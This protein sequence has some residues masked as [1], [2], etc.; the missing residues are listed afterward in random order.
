MTYR[1]KT[2]GLRAGLAA[3]ALALCASSAQAALSERDLFSPFDHAI[4]YDSLTTYEWLDLTK[5]LGQSYNAVLLTPYVTE[6]GFRFATPQE[7][8]Q[9]WSDTG[10]SQGT[11]FENRPGVSLLINLL[12][13][14]AQCVPGATAAAQ[15]W[16]DMGDP[17]MTAYSFVQ[18][19]SLA[20]GPNGP[21][22][23]SGSAN[24]NYAP[25]ASR[26]LGIDNT[27]NGTGSFLV[28][29]AAPEPATW[30]MMIAG[31]GL[32]GS[33]LRRRRLAVAGA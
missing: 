24:M 23:P 7:V 31:F 28:R 16:M 33:A 21:N 13:C 1:I 12:G 29:S 26:D 4:T 32:V 20:A 27:S 3:M 17:L 30:A 2:A 11:S 10:V 8:L 5:T 6:L 22:L 15:G 18:F 19:S 9:L 14:T 25:F